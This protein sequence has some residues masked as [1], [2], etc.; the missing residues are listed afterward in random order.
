MV[1]LLSW[2]MKKPLENLMLINCGH[3]KGAVVLTAAVVSN[4]MDSCS[5]LADKFARLRGPSKCTIQ[6]RKSIHV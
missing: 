4:S 2:I 3:P 6:A 5:L 1:D